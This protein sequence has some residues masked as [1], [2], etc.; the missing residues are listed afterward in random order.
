MKPVTVKAFLIP[1]VIPRLSYRL[2]GRVY[3]YSFLANKFQK[4]GRRLKPFS[5]MGKAIDI[6]ARLPMPAVSR[7]F[8]PST[9]YYSP[10]KASNQTQQRRLNTAEFKD[11]LQAVQNQSCSEL[12]ESRNYQP[13]TSW[14]KFGSILG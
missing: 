5:K 14:S 10:V 2:P 9:G 6:L 1:P 8:G 3:Y 4:P 12:V 7:F 13:H 11:R